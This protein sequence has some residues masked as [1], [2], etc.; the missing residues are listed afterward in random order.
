MIPVT[1]AAAVSA[2]GLGREARIRALKSGQSGLGPCPIPL[3]FSPLV[4]AVP[5][6]LPPLEPFLSRW[7]TPL[8]KMVQH[9]L[10]ELGPALARARERWPAKR[11]AVVLGTSTAGASVTENAYAEYLRTGHLPP[12]YDYETQHTFG[13]V[14]H[15]V[16]QLTG[17]DGPGWVVST[18]CTSSAKTVAS[19][20][21][22]IELG[23]V[24]AALCGGVDTLCAMTLRGFGSLGALAPDRCRPFSREATGINIGEGGALLLLERSGD[25]LGLIEGVGESSDAY[26]VSAPHPEGVGARLAMERALPPQIT[27]E[28]VDHLNAHGTGTT[29]NDRMEARAIRGLF[30][31]NI[32]VISTKGYTGHTLGGAGALELVFALDM[33]LEGFMA[34]SLGAEPVDEELG[35]R[36]ITEP[37]Q[38]QLRRVLS[39]SFAFGGNNISVCLRS[40]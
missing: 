39:N 38:A 10:L 13:A 16:R 29:H 37:V 35:L 19:A 36:V 1:A 31:S 20:A 17:F 14:L 32:P 6:A 33:M 27:P 34:P 15:V 40:P 7:D 24:D 26:H 18:A 3:P 30:G 4:G 23:A 9:L 22:L 25:G 8:T 28:Q 12:A 5:E 11:I 21:R 2:L